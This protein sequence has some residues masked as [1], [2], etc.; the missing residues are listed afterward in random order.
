MNPL[1]AVRDIKAEAFAPPFVVSARGMALRMFSD[2]CSDPK[3]M[4]GR[5]PEDFQLYQ[6]GYFNESTG[7]IEVFTNMVLIGMGAE[8]AAASLEDRKRQSGLFPVVGAT[9]GGGS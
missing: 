3:T 5:H 4:I 7:F 8:V 2:W 9:N 6:L 1:C